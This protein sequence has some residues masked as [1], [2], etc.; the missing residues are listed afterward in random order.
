MLERG[1]PRKHDRGWTPFN[2]V[3]LTAAAALAV[4]WASLVLYGLFDLIQHL[5]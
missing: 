4:G 5:F 2:L 1:P 3:L